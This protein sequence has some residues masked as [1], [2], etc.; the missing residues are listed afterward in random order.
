MKITNIVLNNKSIFNGDMNFL[1]ANSNK[2]FVFDN[3]QLNDNAMSLFNDKDS[4]EK[5]SGDDDD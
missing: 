3:F 2:G 1:N 5:E 4:E